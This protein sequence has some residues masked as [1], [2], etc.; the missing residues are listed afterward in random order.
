MPLLEEPG[1]EV[2][3]AYQYYMKYKTPGQP[4]FTYSGWLHA[5]KPEPKKCSVCSLVECEFKNSLL[6]KSYG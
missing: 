5:G 6:H 4:L 1:P 3:E 2:Y